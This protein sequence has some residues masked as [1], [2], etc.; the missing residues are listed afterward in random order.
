[1]TLLEIE[2]LSHYRCRADDYRNGDHS[3]P[4]VKEALARF[5]DDG[6]LTMAGFNV[7]RFPDGT[8]KA[9]YA[10]TER[11]RAYLDALQSV[12]LPVQEWAMPPEWRNTLRPNG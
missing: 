7:E 11:T 12:P 4:A 10:V 2:I 8:L 3:A 9:R 1:M 6:L 5:V